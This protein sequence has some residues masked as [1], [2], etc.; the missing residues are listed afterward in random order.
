MSLLDDDAMATKSIEYHAKEPLI[1]EN[2]WSLLLSTTPACG[3]ETDVHPIVKKVAPVIGMDPGSTKFVSEMWEITRKENAITN[4]FKKHIGR[5][6]NLLDC[7]SLCKW[8]AIGWLEK[9]SLLPKN[10]KPILVI[11][12]ITEIPDEDIN[13]DDPQIVRNMLLHSWKN[14]KTE[15]FNSKSGHNFT[16]EPKD[17]TVF[18]TWTPENREKMKA[19]WRASDNLCPIGDFRED[20]EE[21]KEKKI[22]EF[23]NL[24]DEEL[25]R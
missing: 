21:Y 3:I 23:K 19:I 16:I 18:V 4:R 15:F 10:P 11:E 5:P 13:H 7:R 24:S 9:V 12:N 14:S 20:F 2:F 22:K 8:D 25:K 1:E 6:I 17:Y